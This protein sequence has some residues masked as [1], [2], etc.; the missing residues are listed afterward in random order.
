MG[1]AQPVQS[2]ASD[3]PAGQVVDFPAV[4]DVEAAG[5]T[6]AVRTADALV[7]GTPSQLQSG[8]AREF[9]ID[10]NCGD[11]TSSGDKFWL[12]CVEKLLSFPTTGS[13]G[14]ATLEVDED[15]PVTAVAQLS[16]GEIFVGSNQE[17]TVS[18]YLNGEKT[19]TFSVAAPTDQLVAVHNTDGVDN[20]VRTWG[21]DTTIQSLDWRNSREGGRL[22]V[23]KGVGQISAGNHG[24]VVASDALGERVAI[25]T[26]QDVVRLHQFG[27][28]P[29]Q[30]WAAAWDSSRQLAWV[31]DLKNNQAQ[32]FEISTGVPVD[33]GRIATVAD[34]RTMAVTDKG[35]VVLGSA[36]GDGLQLVTDPQLD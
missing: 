2:P 34:A 24:V 19:D 27:N 33:K 36:T 30:P 12:A 29:G 28:A 16:T 14:P 6:V 10:P 32:A 20:V 15:F 13:T 5:D 1:N 9:D 25:Y 11:L 23:G 3:S 4:I 21:E 18:V 26:A 17:A 7:V 8:Q 35:T 22:R 31:S